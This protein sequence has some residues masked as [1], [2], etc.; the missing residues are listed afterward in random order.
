MTI[1]STIKLL[2]IVWYHCQVKRKRTTKIPIY[3]NWAQSLNFKIDLN[4]SDKIERNGLQNPPVYYMYKK[5]F[6]QLGTM[7]T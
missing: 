2:L 1:M 6:M 4:F 3:L 5:M 7:M